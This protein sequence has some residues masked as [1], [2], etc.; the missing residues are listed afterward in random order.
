MNQRLLQQLD[1]LVEVDKLKS[2]Y[3]RSY[4]TDRS[5]HENDAEHTWHLTMMAILLLEHVDNQQLD[6]L[7]VLKML[8]VHDLVEIDAGDTFAYDE[9]GHEDKYEREQ[10][11]ARRLFGMLPDDQ[12][13]E[14]MTLWEE[15]EARQSPEAQY[16]AALDR[17]QPLIQNYRTEGVSWREHGVT[18]DKVLARNRHIGDISSELWAYVQSLVA[19]SVNKGYLKP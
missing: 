19:D 4:I 11:A 13:E 15:F 16:A 10:A 17:L 12:R 5:R 1:F 14:L 7:R 6:I 8:I 18:S 3:R 2:V 9:Q